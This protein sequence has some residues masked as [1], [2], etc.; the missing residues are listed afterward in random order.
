MIFVLVPD[1]LG[2]SAVGNS[3][4]DPLTSSPPLSSS[5]FWLCALLLIAVDLCFFAHSTFY[6][7][8]RR[9]HTHIDIHPDEEGGKV[10]EEREP[11]ISELGSCF[12]LMVFEMSS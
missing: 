10:R 4:E 6:E 11:S 12:K 9:P 7:S 3:T 2:D 5:L 8:I 1:A